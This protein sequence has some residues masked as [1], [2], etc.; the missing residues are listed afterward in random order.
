MGSTL[1]ARRAGRA[2][3]A[4]AMNAVRHTAMARASGSAIET[5]YYWL[6]T[7]CANPNKTIDPRATPKK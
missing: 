7:A 2:A 1:D 5:P 3:E 6:R 4:N